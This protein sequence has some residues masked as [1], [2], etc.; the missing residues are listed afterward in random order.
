[1]SR[2]A[3]PRGRG[4]RKVLFT[5]GNPIRQADNEIASGEWD[6]LNASGTGTSNV[7]DD[8]KSFTG[9]WSLKHHVGPTVSA[10]N[11]IARANW[12]APPGS[13]P[14]T[15]PVVEI[16][17][18]AW[19]GGAFYFQD[20]DPHDLTFF[21]RL[22]DNFQVTE[23]N[24]S[25]INCYF[26]S[27]SNEMGVNLKDYNGTTGVP[28]ETFFSGVALPQ[29]DWAFVELGILCSDDPDEG[30]CELWLDNVQVGS[31]VTSRTIK[32]AANMYRRVQFGFGNYLASAAGRE[33]SLWTDRCYLADGRRGPS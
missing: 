5:P 23:P 4:R 9:D 19:I 26:E 1:M 15:D 10:G 20:A 24:T 14:E 16:G 29:D 31:R 32:L 30:W 33:A 22:S 17:Q 28:D 7:R 3:L 2:P 6:Q 27:A 13:A 18:E 25:A 11:P 8:S 12:F 21:M